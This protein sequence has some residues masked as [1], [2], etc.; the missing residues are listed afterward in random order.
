MSNVQLDCVCSRCKKVHEVS[1]KEAVGDI[2]KVATEEG[3]V[4]FGFYCKEC[5][6]VMSEFHER[7][8]AN[9]MLG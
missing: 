1:Y 2:T 6:T 4:F 3:R 7:Y 9:E 5:E 8:I